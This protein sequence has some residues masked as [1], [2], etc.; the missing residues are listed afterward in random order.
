MTKTENYQLNQ[1]EATD[2]ISRAD[3]NADN[4]KIEAVLGELMRAECISINTSDFVA[5]DTIC[6]FEKVP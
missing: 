3:F 6:T 4:A 5:G 2:K 1:W